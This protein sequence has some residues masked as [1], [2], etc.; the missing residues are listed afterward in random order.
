MEGRDEVVLEPRRFVESRV[1]AGDKEVV[2]YVCAHSH[3][4]HLTISTSNHTNAKS[5]CG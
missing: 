5:Y 2:Y 4:R 1:R 3:R